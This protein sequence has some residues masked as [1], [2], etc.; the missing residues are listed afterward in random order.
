MDL[1]FYSDN[2]K[3]IDFI[4]TLTEEYNKIPDEYKDTAT[5]REECGYG[6]DP[7]SYYIAWNRTESD[8]EVDQRID[9]LEASG[10]IDAKRRKDNEIKE[11]ERLK[12]KYG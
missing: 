6:D 3:L 12:K 10:K 7:P 11:Y 2:T 5:I 4:K 8:E 9:M 1:T